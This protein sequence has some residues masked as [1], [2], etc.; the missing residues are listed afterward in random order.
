MTEHDGGRIKAVFRL[1]EIL[2]ALGE[3]EPLSTKEVADTVGVAKSTAHAYLA[4]LHELEFVNRGPRGYSMS[5]KFLDYGMLEREK[6]DVVGAAE[7]TVRQLAADTSEAVYLVVEEHGRGVFVDYAL[8]DRAVKAIARVGVRAP[9]H[10]LASGKAILAHSP[11][12][13]IADIIETRGFE[14]QTENTIESPE[15]LYAELD[16]TL[17]RGYAVN[18]H[19]AVA[20]IR[21]IAAPIT[22]DDRAVA[23]ITVAGPANR[24]TKSHREDEIVEEVL[25]AANEIELKL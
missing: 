7:S 25:A 21:A 22:V 13:R 8:G 23:A 14:T 2:A 19:E 24:I 16:R 1:A 17:E 18:D 20:G 12:E 4:S 5:L 3:E 10:S 11:E 6:L 9:L 15:R